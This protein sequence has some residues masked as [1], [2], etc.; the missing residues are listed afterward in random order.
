MRILRFKKSW[1]ITNLKKWFSKFVKIRHFSIIVL[2]VTYIYVCVVHSFVTINES[3]QTVSVN[4]S[5]KHVKL[6]LLLLL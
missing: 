5:T 2:K 6:L 1:K 3:L 4:I